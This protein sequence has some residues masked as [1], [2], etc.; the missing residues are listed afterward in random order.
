MKVI[1]MNRHQS[2]RWVTKESHAMISISSPGDR[3][4][5]LPLP[6]NRCL[7]FL[8]LAFYDLDRRI[9]GYPRM[10]RRQARQIWRFVQALNGIPILVIHCDAGVSRSP[11]VAAAITKWQTGDDTEWFKRFYPNRWVYRQL[12]ETMP[13]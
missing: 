1:V 12:I 2:E 11:A 6:V 9:H 8:R 13:T 5:V 3:S 10:T 7:K 4:E